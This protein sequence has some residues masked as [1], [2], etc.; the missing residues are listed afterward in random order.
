MTRGHVAVTGKWRSQRASRRHAIRVSMQ[1]SL[2]LLMMMMRGPWFLSGYHIC[3]PLV[4]SLQIVVVGT[5]IHFEYVV[6]IHAYNS[7]VSMLQCKGNVGGA[8]RFES[9]LAH[10]IFLFL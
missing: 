7:V 9:T 6:L 3:E 10:F 2:G 8:G 1:L 5:T 4:R